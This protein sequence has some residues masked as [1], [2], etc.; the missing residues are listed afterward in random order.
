M[1]TFKQYLSEM[2]S[3]VEDEALGHLTHVKD[4]PHE[5]PKFTGLSHELLTK[6]HQH[7]MG[8]TQKVLVQL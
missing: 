2:A 4:I 7:R 8:N 6:F 5:D 3:S 1:K